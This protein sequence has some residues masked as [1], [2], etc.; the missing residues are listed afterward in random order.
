MNKK[1]KTVILDSSVWIAYLLETD[2]SH[3]GAKKIMRY[4]FNQDFCIYMPDIIFY[5]VLSVLIKL[6]EYKSAKYFSELNLN[7]LTITKYE[8]LSIIFKY[9]D[10]FKTKTQDSLII[11]YCLKYNIDCFETFDKK[12]E[13]TYNQIKSL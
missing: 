6:K 13:N 8:F 5:E 12:Q 11:I 1:P 9:K 2:L 10:N 4:Y 7:I 3:L